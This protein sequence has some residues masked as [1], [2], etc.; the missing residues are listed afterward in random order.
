MAI[1][2]NFKHINLATASQNELTTAETINRPP[3]PTTQ[4]VPIRITTNV[5]KERKKERNH[6]HPKQIELAAHRADRAF[7]EAT[8]LRSVRCSR[9]GVSTYTAPGFTA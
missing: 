8:A 1:K 6:H 5:E 4:M 9:P 2:K 3:A 7:N